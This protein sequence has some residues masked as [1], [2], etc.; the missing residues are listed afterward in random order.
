MNYCSKNLLA[1]LL[2]I[3]LGGALSAQP[4]VIWGASG[5]TEAQL[6]QPIN[7]VFKPKAKVTGNPLDLYFGAVFTAENQTRLTVQGFYNGGNEFVVRFSPTQTGNWQFQTFSS[8]GALAGMRGQV[9]VANNQNPNLHGAVVVQPDAPQKFVYQDGTPYFALAFELD[10]LFALDYDNKTD[11]PKTKQLIRA[12]KEGGFNQVVMNVYAYDV[13][14]KVAENVPPAYNFRQPPYSVF[15]GTNQAPDFS[16]L[17]L[18]FF[19]HL[20]RV[21]DHLHQN[22]LVAHLMIYV[23][24][25]KVNWPKMYSP[26]DNRYFDYVVKRYQAYPNILWDVSKEALDYGRCDIPYINER[27]DRIRRN[28]AYRRLVTVHD[29][30]YCAREPEKVDFISIQNW[31]SDLYSSSLEAYQKHPNKPVMNIEHGGYEEGPYLSFTG[32]YVNPETCLVRNYEC[33]FAGIYSTYYWQNAA[34]NV[35]IHDLKNPAHSFAKPRLDYYRHLQAFFS[36]HN[37]NEYQPYKPKLT[38]NSRLGNDNLASSGYPLTNNRGTYLYLV[39]AANFQTNVVVP[40]PDSGKL[41]AQWFNIFT[42]EYR[43][44]PVSDWW[45]WKG[46]QSPWKGQ[47]SILILR[48]AK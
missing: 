24:N 1:A 28:D 6:H 32:N 47:Y 26:D 30:E 5:V 13:G 33:V 29:Y 43:E 40:K 3:G 31:R 38:T 18:A 7:L 8:E 46:Y 2:I 27:I 9:R 20:D 14:W 44:E 37:F 35:V 34:W 16:Q 23:W 25:K 4:K 21:I 36:R 41:A 39:P 17:N 15:G 22:G 45:L 48:E 19:Q 12:V 10:W 11:I 42:G